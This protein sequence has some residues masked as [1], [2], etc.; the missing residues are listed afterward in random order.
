MTPLTTVLTKGRNHMLLAAAAL[1]FAAL[2]GAC[3]MPTG[4]ADTAKESPGAAEA[5]AVP[6]TTTRG[7]KVASTTSKGVLAADG[8][9]GTL[10]PTG[11]EGRYELRL[12]G[13]GDALTRTAAG[14]TGS[15]PLDAFLADPALTDRAGVANAV[16]VVA[17]PALTDQVA[18]RQVVLNV[19]DPTYDRAADALVFTATSI[20]TDE[21]DRELARVAGV[22]VYADGRIE[23]GL[24][25]IDAE[26]L[27]ATGF[28]EPHLY[29]DASGTRVI[30]ECAIIPGTQCPGADLF[31]SDMANA[32]FRGA[33]L[34]KV[35]FAM[36]TLRGATFDGANVAEAELFRSDLSDTSWRDTDLRGANM[37]QLTLVGA[38]MTGARA[39]DAQMFRSELNNATLVDADF[40]RVALQQATIVDADAQ[41]VRMPGSNLFRVDMSGTNFTEALLHDSNLAQTIAHGVRFHG[42]DLSHVDLTHADLRYADLSGA[43]LSYANLAGANLTGANLAG[44]DLTGAVLWL[45][46]LT[47]ANLHGVHWSHTV[48]PD[49]MRSHRGCGGAPSPSVRL[50]VGP[51]GELDNVGPRAGI[52]TTATERD[53]VAPRRNVYSG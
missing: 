7:F 46:N 45:S 2:G 25:V 17:D 40:T 15:L 23:A 1:G 27:V 35:N 4:D 18:Y 5:A 11:E 43:D 26:D 21:I 6:S 9:A 19:G 30:G 38:D 44:A 33:N 3:A 39:T 42:A 49:G 32:D 13:V 12:V 48:C 10:R 16:L 34:S 47:G 53:Y 36:S 37:H 31:R 14:A 28:T 20:G 52:V 24:D 51:R 22:G 29:L 50:D 8:V 41:R